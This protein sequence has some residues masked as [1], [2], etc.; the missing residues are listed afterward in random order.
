MS[1]ASGIIIFF[2]SL[3]ALVAEL[4]LYF[5]AGFGAAGGP[6]WPTLLLR[7]VDGPDG[8]HRRSGVLHSRL[9]PGVGWRAIRRRARPYEA[10][11]RG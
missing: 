5:V 1:L 6:G 2:L 8:A 3:L 11:E 4:I 7:F 10:G 9:A